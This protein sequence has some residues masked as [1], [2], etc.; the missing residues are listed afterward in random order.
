MSKTYLD[1]TIISSLADQRSTITTRLEEKISISL[2]RE[3]GWDP[4]VSIVKVPGCDAYTSI[5]VCASAYRAG[6]VDNLLLLS[7]SGCR[8][9]SADI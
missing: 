3:S 6:V 8:N 4:T 2:T 5:N 7:G 9:G 1:T